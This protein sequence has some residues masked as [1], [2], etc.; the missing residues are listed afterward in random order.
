MKIG[1]FSFDLQGGHFQNAWKEYYSRY[2]DEVEIVIDSSPPAK[3]VYEK[4]AF[5]TPHMEA[6]QKDLFTRNDIV[7]YA[8]I[9]EFLVPEPTMYRDLRHYVEIFACKPDALR[10]SYGMNVVQTMGELPIDFTRPLLNQRRY[11]SNTD[12]YSKVNMSKEPT[13]WNDGMMCFL[14]NKEVADPH[15]KLI[16]LK[17]IDYNEEI[18]RGAE[19]MGYK[20]Q[21]QLKD[22]FVRTTQ[23]V[24]LI[25]ERYKIL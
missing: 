10:K 25:P 11:W 7:I 19:R 8:D 4:F 14:V 3:T 20:D 6:K 24:E 16:H 18:K 21:D 5:I 23:G 9:D 12:F 15:L 1:A 22:S 13:K 2:C 17:H